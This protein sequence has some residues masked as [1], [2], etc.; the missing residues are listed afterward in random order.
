MLGTRTPP[1]LE[2]DVTPGYSLHQHSISSS[3]PCVVSSFTTKICIDNW[4]L[5]DITSGTGGKRSKSPSKLG[6]DRFLLLFCARRSV[7]ILETNEGLI[8]GTHH[9]VLR[10]EG[11][12]CVLRCIL[13]SY[14]PQCPAMHRYASQSSR[15]EEP[16]D[17]YKS[18]KGIHATPPPHCG[19]ELLARYRHDLHCN[20]GSDGTSSPGIFGHPTPHKHPCTTAA[21][22]GDA[23]HSKFRGVLRHILL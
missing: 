13:P 7:D 19:Y 17:I 18:I 10:I 15:P 2:R 8:S 4:A 22:R 16:S 5:V 11:T 23:R 1:P 9:S 14:P 12:P 3:W 21:S 6:L 20:R